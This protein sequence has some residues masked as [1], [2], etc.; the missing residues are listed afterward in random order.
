[1]FPENPEIID[2]KSGIDA[3]R[4]LI[5]KANLLLKDKPVKLPEYEKWNEA[6][7]Y[8]LIKIY[9]PNSANVFTIIDCPCD[10]AAWSDM[11]FGKENFA[12]RQK[13][14]ENYATSCL[15]VRSR[16]L[17]SSIIALM[18]QLKES[19]GKNKSQSLQGK[20]FSI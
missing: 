13:I 1:M 4:G 2:V 8:C 10:D 15:E 17:D 20:R 19:E 12:D 3:L 16:L 11:F 14:T 9:G 18:A 6:T 5:E 7:R